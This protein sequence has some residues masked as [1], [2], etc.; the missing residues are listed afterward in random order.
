[1]NDK[2]I[3]RIKIDVTKPNNEMQKPVAPAQKNI[4]MMSSF[5]VSGMV[6]KRQ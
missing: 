2:F 3:T 1:M 5:Y 4:T 6:M